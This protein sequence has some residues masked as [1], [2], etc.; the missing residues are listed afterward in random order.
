VLEIDP[1]LSP[2][3]VAD[4]YVRQRRN[5]LGNGRYR[6]LDEKHLHLAIFAAGCPEDESLAASLERWN[7][8]CVSQKRRDWKY[9]AKD[10]TNFGRDLSVDPKRLLYPGRTRFA[11]YGFTATE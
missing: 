9:R 1:A 8:F 5:F 11:P 10:L 4:A 2:R 3:D 7:K 6:S